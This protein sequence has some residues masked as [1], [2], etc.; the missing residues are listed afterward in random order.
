MVRVGELRFRVTQRLDNRL[1]RDQ[2]AIQNPQGW[3]NSWSGLVSTLSTD[4]NTAARLLIS[5][6][7]NPDIGGLT[8][9]P[10]G[11]LPLTERQLIELRS[12][13]CTCME[14]GEWGPLTMLSRP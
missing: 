5:P 3:I 2:S 13:K 11:S 7:T 12:A 9:A 6:L 1:D 10:A 4:T 8:C 14:S